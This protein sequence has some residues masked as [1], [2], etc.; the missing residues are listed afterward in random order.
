MSQT[1][2]RGTDLS[3]A[4]P[5]TAQPQIVVT[6]QHAELVA[7]ALR[8]IGGLGATPRE[9]SHELELVLM[10]L[11]LTTTGKDRSDA[12]S[13]DQVFDQLYGYFK[14][15]YGDWV[16]TFGKN[17]DLA[18]VVPQHQTVPGGEAE[19]VPVPVGEVVRQST[20][21]PRRDGRAGRARGHG[22]VRRTRLRGHVVADG[23]AL[24][25][26]G[27]NGLMAEAG[28]GTFVTGRILEAAPAATAY[29]RRVLDVPPA[30]H[31]GPSR[32]D[33]W[34]VATRLV[35]LARDHAQVI[36]LSLGCRTVDGQPPLV[37]AR[38]LERLGPDVVVAAAAGNFGKHDKPVGPVW[39]AAFDRVVAVGATDDEGTR[40]TYS[41]DPRHAPWVDVQAPGHGVVSLFPK[42]ELLVTNEDGS[43]RW[44]EFK[45]FARWSGTS[46]AAA[47]V[48]GLI[49]ARTSP[50]SVGPWQ[51]LQA[52]I[53]EAYEADR[54]RDG[55]PWLV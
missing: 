47:H 41:P 52:L 20:V 3:V 45:G 21:S 55:R 40:P 49:A 27:T 8:G 44:E 38:A 46:F 31:P 34:K 12:L 42:G 23:D 5:L 50:G 30:S 18:S 24:L 32:T 54:L 28:H 1:P 36:N 19:P 11:D 14:D 2:E 53:E 4:F 22:R 10:D 29:L 39:P 7:A 9:E 33:S 26:P 35:R 51:A 15:E 25:K 37:F 17:R 13:L 6:S 43:T 16:P 48:T